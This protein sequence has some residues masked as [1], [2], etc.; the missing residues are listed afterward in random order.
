MTQKLHPMVRISRAITLLAYFFLGT[1]SAQSLRNTWTSPPATGPVIAEGWRYNLVANG[2]NRP[3]SMVMDSLGNILIL[4]QGRGIT[5]LE[6]LNKTQEANGDE[7]DQGPCTVHDSAT[8]LV[9]DSTVSAMPIF[10]VLSGSVRE[11]GRTD[12]RS[13]ITVFS[14]LQ[15][16]HPF[17]P[18]PLDRSILGFTTP[19]PKL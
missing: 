17:T 10:S 6:Y 2:L 8:V 9:E 3:R 4:E 1:A 18:H 12:P 16:V 7:E 14:S 15:T 11:G 19:N 5:H 13:S